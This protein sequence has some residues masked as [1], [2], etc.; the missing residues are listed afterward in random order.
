VHI[1]YL[2]STKPTSS[3]IPFRFSWGGGGGYL[4]R[5]E[6]CKYV[7]G[8]IYDETREER[9]KERYSVMK[10]KEKMQEE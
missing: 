1:I 2:G 5:H 7:K 3:F 6:A 8:H 9:G 4:L 10:R